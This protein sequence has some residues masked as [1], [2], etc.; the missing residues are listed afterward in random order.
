MTWTYGELWLAIAAISVLTY[1]SRAVPFVFRSAPVFRP[2][3]PAVRLFS[4]LGATLLAALAAAT[5][6]P[7]FLDSA[8]VGREWVFLLSAIATVVAAIWRRQ[9][10]LAVLAGVV[11]FYSCMAAVSG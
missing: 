3:S 8:Q 10:G 5:V 6:V 7:V 1:L 4:I 2:T 11:M 9:P